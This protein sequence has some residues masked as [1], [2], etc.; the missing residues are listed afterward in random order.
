VIGVTF[1]GAVILY[2]ATNGLWLL[3]GLFAFLLH[4]AFSR[5]ETISN[6]WASLASSVGWVTSGD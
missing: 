4:Q 5:L 1:L 6:N 3:V 2:A